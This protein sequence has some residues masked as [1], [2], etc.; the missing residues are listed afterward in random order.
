MDGIYIRKQFKVRCSRIDRVELLES[1]YVEKVSDWWL[2]Y[3][4]AG[5]DVSK[6][7]DGATYPR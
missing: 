3:N 4:Q 5:S 1:R 6:T 2:I 7:L